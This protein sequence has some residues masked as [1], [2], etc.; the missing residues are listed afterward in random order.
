M[1]Q[2]KWHK[3]SDVDLLSNLDRVVDL[4]TE[5]SDRAFDLGMPKQELDCPVG[6]LFAGR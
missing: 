3:K 4:D 1:Q 5:V 6:F 2:Y